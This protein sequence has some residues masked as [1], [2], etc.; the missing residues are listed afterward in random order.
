VSGAPLLELPPD[1]TEADAEIPAEAAAL[2]SVAD[3]SMPGPVG[4]V[5]APKDDS[6]SL[7][8]S[9]AAASQQ[10][11]ANAATQAFTP[12][13][14]MAATPAQMQ[15]DPSIAQGQ[16]AMLAAAQKQ[17][18]A[19]G[20]PNIP[21]S[22]LF[23]QGQPGMAPRPVGMSPADKT[24]GSQLAASAQQAADDRTAMLGNVGD[25]ARNFNDQTNALVEDS[26]LGKMAFDADQ[27]KQAEF[28][29][30]FQAE[31]KDQQSKIRDKLA[32]LEAQGVNPNNYWQKAGTA[33]NILSAIS[34][35]LGGFAAGLSPHLGGR[36]VGAEMLN[37][38]ITRDIDAQKTN[39]Q[40]ALMVAG[41]QS[42]L[43]NDSFEH[44]N[45]LLKAERDST[46]SAY[47]IAQNQIMKQAALY[48]DNSDVQ[49]QAQSMIGKT[50]ESLGDKIDSIQSR[51]W[52]LAKNAEKMTGGT[53]AGGQMTAKD[54]A[55]Q[56]QKMVADSG[57]TMPMAEAR[58]RVIESWTGVDRAPDVPQKP[59]EKPGAGGKGSVG[60]G[61]AILMREGSQLDAAEAAATELAKLTQGGIQGNGFDARGRMAALSQQLEQA[62]FKGA[63]TSSGIT[64]GNAAQAAQI[65]QDVKNRKAALANRLA[66]VQR[67]G[68][69]GGDTGEEPETP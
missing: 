58:R 45:A 8:S 15:A 61:A 57:G 43:N 38:A 46:L 24:Y 32:E 23:G 12:S 20:A 54:L 65:L 39:L 50:N 51:Q 67:L 36:N 18:A 37:D 68:G 16:Q 4:Q 10:P 31:T 41:K 5:E 56:S 49:T 29:K 1:I 42:D 40:H 35:G 59:Y 27:K 28:S 64:G 33:S 11:A 62:G 53:S 3:P 22:V 60:R 2:T 55:E 7:W 25:L 14:P 21:N 69:G 66:E 52:Q 9:L 47:T 6:Q 34:V 63:P 26:Q 13:N 17:Q 30:Q 44:Q 48:K 19:Q